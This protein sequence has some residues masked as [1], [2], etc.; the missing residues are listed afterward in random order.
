ME[1]FEYPDINI[2]IFAIS[3]NVLKYTYF[4]LFNSVQS[5]LTL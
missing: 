1:F 5:C 3:I 4:L 2:H